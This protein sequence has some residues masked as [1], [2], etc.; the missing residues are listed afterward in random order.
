MGWMSA[1]DLPSN[2]SNSPPT[3]CS[4]IQKKK[5]SDETVKNPQKKD[6]SCF[7]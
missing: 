5:K 6:C 2:I 7:S 4:S 1:N 3:V